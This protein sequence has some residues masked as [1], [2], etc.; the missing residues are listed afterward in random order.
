[1]YLQEDPVY[2]EY[3]NSVSSQRTNAA[4]TSENNRN[5]YSTH[6]SDNSNETDEGFY[7]DPEWDD[8]VTFRQL[9]L[10]IRSS[11]ASLLDTLDETSSLLGVGGF[12]GGHQRRI[13]SQS[14]LVNPHDFWQRLFLNWSS[15]M[16]KRNLLLVIFPVFVVCIFIL[17]LLNC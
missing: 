6:D 13:S 2:S 10:P 12:H 8:M 5:S 14:F 16:I 11:H 9:K 7:I 17:T 1:M 15:S 4:N 3:Y